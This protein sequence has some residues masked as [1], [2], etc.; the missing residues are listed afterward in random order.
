[1]NDDRASR[2]QRRTLRWAVAAFVFVATLALLMATDYMYGI[3]YDEPIYQSKSIQVLEWLR[4]FAENPQFA[5]SQQA[6]DLY[7]YAK[8][9]HPGFFKIVTA[10]AGTTL[11]RL[12]PPNATWRTGTNLLAAACFAALY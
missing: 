7:W 5:C 9:E 8:D 3:T 11:G 1:M 10:V 4:L 2:R 12:V 6:V